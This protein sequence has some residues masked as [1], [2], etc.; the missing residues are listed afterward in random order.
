MKTVQWTVRKDRLSAVHATSP[1][2]DKRTACGLR[3]GYRPVYGEARR[4]SEAA[5]KTACLRCWA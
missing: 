3:V 5:K 2:N 4:P 1:L